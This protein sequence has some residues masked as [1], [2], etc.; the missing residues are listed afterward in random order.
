MKVLRLKNLLWAIL[1]LILFLFSLKMEQARGPFLMG[2]LMDPNYMYLVSS[3]R[4]SNGQSIR[5]TDHPGTPVQI[6][7]GFTSKI[8]HSYRLFTEKTTIENYEQDVTLHAENYLTAI[9]KVLLAINLIFLYLTGFFIWKITKN[10]TWA[11]LLQLAPFLVGAE[12][13]ESLVEVKP[14]PMLLGT[15]VF[16]T[17][18][19]FIY[20]FQEKNKGYKNPILMGIVCGLGV[21]VKVT[22]IPILM[23]PIV[24]LQYIKEKVFFLFTVFISF[25]I[26]TLPIYSQYIRVIKWIFGIAVHSGAYG[27][28]NANIVEPAEFLRNT[29]LIFVNN[30]FSF[31]LL[32]I[33]VVVLVVLFLKHK[34]FK[35]MYAD[36]WQRWLAAIII[37]HF[38][39]LVITAKHYFSNRYFLPI[40][41]LSSFNLL[42][43]FCI[44]KQNFN[45]KYLKTITIALVSI[46][47][48]ISFSKLAHSL[49]E[50]SENVEEAKKIEQL[51]N[52]QYNDYTIIFYVRSSSRVHALLH[53]LYCG[54]IDV[55]NCKQEFE[56]NYIYN[57]RTKQYLD[58]YT[59]KE[60]S[61]NEIME[62]SAGKI[63]FW[64][65]PFHLGYKNFPQD[66][67]NA[68][69]LDY[70]P[71]DI[72]LKDVFNGK[73][74]TIYEVIV[75]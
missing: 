17:A 35:K 36:N 69:Y 72:T 60:I 48:F 25:I 34:S 53:F 1:P 18:L 2:N 28:G 22:F 74:E 73:Y 63:I 7:G 54:G 57:V 43:L 16:A 65:T 8:L 71:P 9:Q 19:F 67:R 44:V 38:V 70:Y 52:N 31:L 4:F 15:T 23:L 33:S 59:Y 62:K 30:P 12:L 10:I 68:R 27:K 6:I 24:G 50:Q 39:G 75:K 40:Q 66:K 5:H 58:S 3:V 26:F 37:A 56:N 14:E 49:K 29:F 55:S 32:L 42:I 64:G 47:L 61:W 51:I 45:F 41:L 46:F 11:F 20:F 21:A 13:F